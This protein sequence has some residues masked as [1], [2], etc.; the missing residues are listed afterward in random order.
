MSEKNKWVYGKK[1]VIYSMGRY[2]YEGGKELSKREVRTFKNWLE[3]GSRKIS[4]RPR[5]NT[6]PRDIVKRFPKGMKFIS[7]TGHV[8]EWARPLT[9]SSGKNPNLNYRRLGSV[10]LKEM[11]FHE[12]KKK[13]GADISKHQRLSGGATVLKGLEGL[14][15]HLEIV[16]HALILQSE[17][18]RISMAYR[19]LKVFQNS[20]KYSKFYTASSSRWQPLSPKTLARRIKRKTGTKILIEYRDLYNSIKVKEHAAP[21]ISSVYT[22]I[23]PANKDH[24]KKRSI[25]YAGFHNESIRNRTFPRRQF[26]GHSSYLSPFKDPFIARMVKNYLFDSVFVVGKK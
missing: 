5:N 1:T 25:C 7:P 15:K 10:D 24:H 23:V 3:T 12:S 19:A 18:F 8:K 6:I 17:N 14:V 2:Y 11:K 13:W 9:L 21:S 16:L 22:D 26:M 4:T 20:F